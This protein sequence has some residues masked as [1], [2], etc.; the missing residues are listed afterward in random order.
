MKAPNK[1]LLT[2][3][4]NATTEAERNAIRKLIAEGVYND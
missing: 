1:K 3:L 4:R 2:A